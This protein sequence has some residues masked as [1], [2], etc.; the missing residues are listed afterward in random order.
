MKKHKIDEWRGCYPSAWK[1]KIV[2][3]AIT[4]PAKFS[5]KLI[6]RIYDH[7][8]AEG[9]LKAGDMVIDPFGGVA[10]GALDAMRHGLHWR[11]IELEPR[12]AD[13]GRQNIAMWNK[14]FGTMPGWCQDAVLLRGDSRHLMEVLSGGDGVVSSPPYTSDALGHAGEPNE[15]DKKKRLY[16]RMAGNSYSG[17]VG[18]PPYADGAQH[19][20]G[21]S[22]TSLEFMSAKQLTGIGL[23]G[24]VSSPPY[25]EARIGQESGQEHAGRG[26]QYGPTAGQ[27]GAMKADGFD[28]AIASPAYTGNVQVEKNAKSIDLHKQWENY[29]NTGGMSTDPANLGNPTGADQTNFWMA[30]RQI[31]D[32][33]FMVLRPGAHAVWVVK[34]FVKNKQLVDFPG[35]WRQLCEAAG[36]VTVHE[37]HALLV[38]HKGSSHTLEGGI[39]EHKTEAKS[40]F[41]R[42]AES[43]GSPPIDYETVLCMEKPA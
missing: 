26:D 8:I 2:P 23:A 29:R 28:A 11:G 15:I 19:Q 30:A 18:S 32:Q 1:G 35:Q 37:H 43:K 16:S 10:L 9:W 31:V 14:Q 39:V 21:D 3:E 38:N 7:M 42:L 40:F 13:L 27:L 4:H 22:L 12:F 33:V 34:G 5:N 20:G 17:A 41:R 6:R 25:S 24:G 36:F